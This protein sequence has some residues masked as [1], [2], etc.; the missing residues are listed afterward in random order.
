MKFQSPK[1]LQNFLHSLKINC[2]Y[3]PQNEILANQEIYHLASPITIENDETIV[4]LEDFFLDVHSIIDIS[5]SDG[6]HVDFTSDFKKATI[7]V[8]DHN[9]KTVSLLTVK[10]D[11]SIYNII[12]LRSRKIR[13]HLEYN[14]WGNPIKTVQIAGSLNSWNP[15][16]YYFKQVG[17]KFEIEFD[18]EPGI[19]TY[20]LIADGNWF[21]DPENPQKV[22][23]GYGSYNSLL[24]V[25][26]PYAKDE[27]VIFTEKAYD[28]TV[29]VLSDKHV[30]DY[31]VLWQNQVLEEPNVFRNED[32]LMINIPEQAES[33]RRSYI[34]VW[35]YNKGGYTND[36]LIPLEYG[37]VLTDSSKLDRNDKESQVIY[38]LM[39]DR[40]SNG[41]PANDQAIDEPDL[42]A[43]L[44]YHGGDI[45]GISQKIKE[46]YFTKLGINTIWVSPVVQNPTH[47]CSKHGKKS[48]GYHGYWPTESKKVDTRF[49]T[50]EVFKQMVENAHDKGMNVILDFVANHVHE[51]NPLIKQHPDWATPL[52]LPDGSLNIGRWEDHRFTTWF[53]EFLPTLDYFNPKVVE[54]MTDIALYWAAEFNLDGFRHD[55]TKHIPEIFWRSLTKKLKGLMAK[56]NKRLYQIGETFGG[57][58]LLKIYVNSG[59]HDGQFSFNLY[60]ESRAAFSMPDFSFDKLAIALEQ[61]LKAFGEHNL[62]GNISGNQDMPRFIS[63]AGEDLTYTQNA[64]HEAWIRYISVKNPIGYKR[65]QGLMAFNCTI[66]GVPII[67]YGDEIGMAGGGDP[68][69]RRPMKFFGL[70]EYEQENLKV[71][72]KIIKIRHSLLSLMY[73]EY[74]CLHVDKKSFAYQRNYFDESTI[75]VFNKKDTETSISINLQS[76]IAD[77]IYFDNFGHDFTIVG[78]ILKIIM[79]PWSFEILSTKNLSS[80]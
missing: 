8:L 12:L 69:N 38:F 65:L 46:G 15:S 72:S 58:D 34:R 30:D 59:I 11:T 36:L 26:S 33:M 14:P 49:G 53:D 79:K 57:R 10:T 73:G 50:K 48:S 76:R 78:T 35:A 70:N 63:Y 60:Y 66:P 5:V 74:K 47:S 56:N 44:N 64:E 67:Y 2:Y 7:S 28:K 13:C 32:K 17:S 21:C 51:D 4:N 61:D 54:A 71:T 42:H 22:D 6:F 9:Y 25:R 27:A 37:T 41:N 62:M 16:Q 77:K 29:V 43:K 75:V 24:E 55:A 1:L 40:F 68:D 23:N 31:V 3:M 52:H 39:V 45:L 18:L 19:Y 20:Q 80:L